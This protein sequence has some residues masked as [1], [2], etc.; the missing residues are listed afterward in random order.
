MTIYHIPGIVKNALPRAASNSN[1][2]AGF[3]CTGIFPFSESIFEEHEFSPSGV[4]DRELPS[5]LTA[6]VD[7]TN[8]P[9]LPSPP[10]SQNDHAS[11]KKR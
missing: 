2:Q 4:T 11:N 6:D 1:V 9:S 10:L 8:E 7:S 3:Q 5:A